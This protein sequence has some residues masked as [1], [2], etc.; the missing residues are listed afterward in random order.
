[1]LE[2]TVLS[3][4]ITWEALSYLFFYRQL[5]YVTHLEWDGVKKR[6]FGNYC[7]LKITQLFDISPGSHIDCQLEGAGKK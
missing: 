2:P 6:G 3:F 4:Q 5:I 1:M 7:L